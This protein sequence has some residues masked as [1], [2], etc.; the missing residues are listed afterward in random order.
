MEITYIGNLEVDSKVTV[1]KFDQ[2]KYGN[3]EYLGMVAVQIEEGRSVIVDLTLVEVQ[4]LIDHLTKVLKE[5]KE[6]K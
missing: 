4:Q 3:K 2:D 6:K 1:S 5:H